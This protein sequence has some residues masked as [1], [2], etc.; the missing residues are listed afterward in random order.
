MK[1]IQSGRKTGKTS[2]IIKMVLEDNGY[3][4]T[5]NEVEVQRLKRIEPK[6]E[7]RVFSWHSLPDILLQ[8][9]FKIMN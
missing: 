6:L 9:L 2:K 8:N 5:F 4:L 1:I 7:G 3:L